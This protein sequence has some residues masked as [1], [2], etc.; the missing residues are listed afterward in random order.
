MKSVPMNLVTQANRQPPHQAIRD[1]YSAALEPARW[2]A[3]LQ[4]V[5][6]VFADVG[7]ILIY[8]RDDGTFGV[9]CSPSLPATSRT[10]AGGLGRG[11][12]A[13]SPVQ[14]PEELGR[15]LNHAAPARP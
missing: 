8:A 10:T 2:P 15:Q 14:R 5:A 7:S 1:I 12:H 11:V 4:A 3:A 9:V 6:D 13:R